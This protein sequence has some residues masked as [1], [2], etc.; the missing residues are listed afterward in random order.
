MLRKVRDADNARREAERRRPSD[1][2]EHD[3]FVF[4]GEEGSFFV[5]SLSSSRVN[6]EVYYPINEFNWLDRDSVK[7]KLER[8]IR[9]WLSEYSINEV[10]IYNS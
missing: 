6:V 10:Y 2:V 4:M 8:F 7:R 5:K 1:I 3:D 9:D